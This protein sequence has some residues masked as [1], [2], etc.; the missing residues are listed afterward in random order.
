MTKALPTLETARLNLRPFLLSDAPV[1]QRLAG[2]REVAETTLSIPHPYGDGVAESW[3]S[4]H[5]AEFER[6][7]S[8]TWAVTPRPATPLIGAISLAVSGAHNR[9]ELG[10]WIGV[11]FWNQGYCTEAGRSVLRYGFGRLACP[12][13]CVPLCRESGLG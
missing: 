3:I 5:Q 12:H 11:P 2:A 4:A 10:Y 6:G 13:L 7:E 8:V 1:V 9:A